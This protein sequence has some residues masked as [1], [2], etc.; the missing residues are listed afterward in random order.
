MT[1][2]QRWMRSRGGR[3]ALLMSLVL[4]VVITLGGHLGG[5][6]DLRSLMGTAAEIQAVQLDDFSAHAL[7][8]QVQVVWRTTEESN[9][10]GFIVWR[11]TPENPGRVRLNE[12]L[13]PTQGS[14]GTYEW[15]DAPLTAGTYYYWLDDVTNYGTVHGHGPVEVVVTGAVPNELFLPVVGISDEAPPYPAPGE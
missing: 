7:G 6:W 8:E 3:R 12:A 15:V 10:Q 14:S 2:V 9:N 13:V 4:L 11:S 5:W 1:R